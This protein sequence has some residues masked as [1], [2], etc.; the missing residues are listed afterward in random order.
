MQIDKKFRGSDYG[1]Q[2]AV[3]DNCYYALENIKNFKNTIY[4]TFNKV[5]RDENSLHDNLDRLTS[6]SVRDIMFVGDKKFVTNTR[7]KLINSI[8]KFL[9]LSKLNCTIEVANDP[10]F[11]SNINKKVF[12]DALDLKYEILA[13]IPFLKKKIAIGSINFHLNTFGKAFKIYK[14]NNFIF[15]G[16]IGIGFERLLLAFYSQFGNNVKFW[17]KNLKKILKI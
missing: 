7:K 12:Q 15:S 14:K 17:P 2:P 1:L 9:R 16:C 10:F 8:K 11:V 6:F 13:E 5:F 4:T 3:C